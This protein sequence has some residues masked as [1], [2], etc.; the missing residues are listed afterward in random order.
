[1][2]SLLESHKEILKKLDAIE[3]KD[4]EQDGNI[5]VIFE[6]LNATRTIQTRG[7]CL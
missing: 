7:Y 3:R 6:Y 4:I 1:M 5:A 2:R